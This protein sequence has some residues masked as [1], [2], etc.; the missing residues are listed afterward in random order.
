M[1]P[2]AMLSCLQ[3]RARCVAAREILSLGLAAL[4]AVV[5]GNPTFASQHLEDFEALCLPLMASQLVG[6]CMSEST[7]VLCRQGLTRLGLAGLGRGGCEKPYVCQPAPQGL[8]ALCLPLL[9]SHLV[10]LGVLGHEDL[11]RLGLATQGAVAV[12]IRILVRAFFSECLAL[13]WALHR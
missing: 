3:V 5:V 7:G 4:G 13:A 12:G 1:N 8:A 11:I 9:A 2:T 10:G 6:E